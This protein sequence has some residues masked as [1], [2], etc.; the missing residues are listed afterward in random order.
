MIFIT[1]ILAYLVF[2]VGVGLWRRKQVRTQEDFIVAGRRL[3]A[4]VLVGTLLATW[5]GSGSLF[6]GGRLGYENGFAALWGAGGSWIGIAIIYFVAQKV[7]RGKK[8]SVPHILEDR[9]SKWVG[10]AATVTTVIAYV[11]IVSYQ[12][13]GGGRVINLIA[14][15]GFSVFGMSSLMTG[16]VITAVFAIGY[17][18][19]AGMISVTYTDVLN[20][21]VMLAG[22][23][24]AIPFAV[25]G[26]GGL[27][28]F[29]HNVPP[30]KWQLFGTMGSTQAF[31]Y[32]LPTMF[33]LLGDANMYQ[34][35]LSARD[36]FEAKRSVRGWIVGTILVE[37]LIVFLAFLGTQ[38]QT[39]LQGAQA[40]NIIPLIA[41][42]H[43]PV[44]IGCLL[45]GAMVA[46]IVSTAD[47]YLLVP[48]TNI[49]HDL[50]LR[51]F[52]PKAS[53]KEL[54]LVSR[55]AVLV[56]GIMA[57]LMISFFETILDAAYAAYTVYG[58]GIT[59]SLLAVFVWKRAS[60][61]G[62]ILSVL[63][64]TIVT[65]GWEIAKKML[66][67]AP[68][69]LEAIYPALVGSILLLVAGSLIWPGDSPDGSSA[70]S[71]KDS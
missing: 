48:S 59:P 42:Q 17:T 25:K 34:R 26:V 54:L 9:Y 55:L 61:T 16:I 33:L 39:G 19:L 64:G 68:L 18:M 67:H 32:L 69:G 50:Y 60:S 20:G 57:F 49:S 62:A 51:Y 71:Q 8:L 12:L 37:T 13:K 43:V 31:A 22:I 56:L 46:I 36:E 15:D 5:T 11:T 23:T 10:L 14:G 2:L 29:A 52:R 63:G 40:A 21:I 66:G 38:L 58:A 28:N 47:S 70:T 41:V 27:A 4:P 30:E 45:L 7:R 35:F 65:L 6:N 1:F 24:F 53:Q 3:T 44:A